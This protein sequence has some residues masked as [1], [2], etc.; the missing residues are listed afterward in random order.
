MLG[1]GLAAAILIDATLVRGVALPA[2][3]ALLGDRGWRVPRA[4]PARLGSWAP[5]VHPDRRPMPADRAM[6]ATSAAAFALHAAISAVLGLV[7]TI[8]WA[9]SPAAATFWPGWVWIGARRPPVALHAALRWALPLEPAGVRAVAIVGSLSAILFGAHVVDLG[10]V[11]RRLLLAA[12]P[13]A[14]PGDGDGDP[15]RRRLPRAA[16]RRRPRAGA[17]RARRRADPHPA[18]RRRGAGGRAAADRARPARRRA[19]AAR[20]AEH[21]ARPGR[22]AARRPARGRRPRAPGARRG[23][24]GDRRAARPRP[25]DRPA[26]ARR[27]RARRGGRGA[28]PARAASRSRSTR[29]PRRA[30]AARWSRPRPTS[31]SPRR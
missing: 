28:R 24:R 31:S 18:R 6:P 3:V 5:R 13:G 1:V 11:G 2:V 25:R 15:R 10:A 21:A 8:V 22:G 14:G 19:G 9:R 7:V 16:V 20:R 4:A 23:G 27:P 17:D 30:P 12:V 26:G 29:R